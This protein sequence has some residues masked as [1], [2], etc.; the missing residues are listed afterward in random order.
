MSEEN[1]GLGLACGPFGEADKRL[2][3]EIKKMKKAWR[4]DVRKNMKAWKRELRKRVK[5]QKKRDDLLAS[6]SLWISCASLALSVAAL[7]MMLMEGMQ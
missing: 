1:T 2:V 5:H 3:K 6:I 4:R 7:L